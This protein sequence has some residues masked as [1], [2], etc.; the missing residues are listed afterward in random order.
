LELSGN[1]VSDE[2]LRQVNDYL[3]RNK[4]GDPIVPQ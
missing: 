2:V 4:N 1:R 3:T